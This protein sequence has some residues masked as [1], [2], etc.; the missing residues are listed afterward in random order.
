MGSGAFE[1]KSS[2]GRNH[3]GSSF[4]PYAA[5]ANWGSCRNASL[6][7]PKLTLAVYFISVSRSFQLATWARRV[8]FGAAT[9]YRRT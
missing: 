3:E 4:S 9:S 1:I 8:L 6:G 2:A 7:I 5:A